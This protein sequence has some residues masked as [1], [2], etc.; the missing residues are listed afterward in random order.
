MPDPLD[1][2]EGTDL[3]NHAVGLAQRGD[4]VRAEQYITASIERGYPIAEAMPMLLRVCIASA[5]LAS[6]LHYAQPYLSD[7]PNDW[8]L[9]YLVATI[10]IGLGNIPE[11]REEL[12]KVIAAVPEMPVPYYTLGMLHRDTLQNVTASRPLLERYLELAPEGS[13][14]EEVRAALTPTVAPFPVSPQTDRIE[15]IERIEH[16]EN[17]QPTPE[18]HHPPPPGSDQ[19]PS[20]SP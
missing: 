7:H 3:F 18:A 4:H 9:R 14:A 11:A 6:A 10:Q 8:A 2:V 19:P 17:F 12:E 20:H 13:H 1:D 15:R 16:I 5:R